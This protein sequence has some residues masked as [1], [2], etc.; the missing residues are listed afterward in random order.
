MLGIHVSL[1]GVAAAK[2]LGRED[3]WNVHAPYD[4]DCFVASLLARKKGITSPEIA[5]WEEFLIQSRVD[6]SGR[7]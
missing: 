3:A 4:R 1:R 7:W 5:D 2:K 6:S